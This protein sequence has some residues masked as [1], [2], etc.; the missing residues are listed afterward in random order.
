VR[1][2]NLPGV[3]APD[4]RPL[5]ESRIHRGWRISMVTATFADPEGNRFEREV[6]RHP[7]A[8]AVVPLH[9]DGSVTLVRQY[10]PAVDRHLLEVP[11][12]IRDVDGEPPELTARREL[13][14]ETGLVAERVEPLVGFYN[15]PGFCDQETLLF[16]ATGLQAGEASPAGAEE[17]FMEVERVALA[18]LDD[19]TRRRVLVDAQTLIGLQLVRERLR[20]PA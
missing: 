15:S 9:E 16:V 14:E 4:F 19:L 10:R 1:P 3:S 2:G 13:Q 5:G 18:E 17:R 6:V 20:S 11:A 7:G 8:V 12:G